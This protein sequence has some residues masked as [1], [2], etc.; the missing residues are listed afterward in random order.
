MS[1]HPSGL[2]IIEVILVMTISA[3]LFGVV[4]GTFATRRKAAADDA[5]RQ[6]MSEIAKVRNQAQQ[7]QGYATEAGKTKLA[8]AG[9]NELFG[10]AILL[11]NNLN[12]ITVYKLMQ[13]R[14][15]PYTISTISVYETSIISMPAE[16]K[17]FIA[18]GSGCVKF[19]SC[20]VN[21]G[22]NVLSNMSTSPIN[23]SAL[24]NP[25]ILLVFRNNTGQSYAFAVPNGAK[26]I[27]SA[28]NIDSY[29]TD[30]QSVLRLAFGIPG[31][32]DTDLDK[33]AAGSSKYYANF[34][35]AIPNNQDL[36]VVK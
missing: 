33:F 18:T 24:S 29:V 30:R 17:W 32:G 2:A 1:S 16:L 12:T 28:S 19:T 14:T 27:G 5:A 11:G 7:G 9:G 13:S 3:L 25:N 20:Y 21:T 23:L 10:Q 6:V 26:D 34:D 31:T 22:T 15:T 35:L 4:I 8:A 36:Q